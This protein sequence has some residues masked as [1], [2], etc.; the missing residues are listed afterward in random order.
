[1]FPIV[2]Q[3][4]QNCAPLPSIRVFALEQSSPRIRQRLPRL[5]SGGIQH[6]KSVFPQHLGYAL[7][8]GN[9]PELRCRSF[10]LI[11]LTKGRIAAGLIR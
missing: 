9:V 10:S 5:G 8:G 1:M 11:R 3:R 2:L 7:R 6:L 4:V